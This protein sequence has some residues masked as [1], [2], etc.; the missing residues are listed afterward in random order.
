MGGAVRRAVAT[1]VAPTG[2]RGRPL[3]GARDEAAPFGGTAPPSPAAGGAD[4]GV[5]GGDGGQ[6]DDAAG[7]AIRGQD[8]RGLV[9]AHQ[10]RADRY[11]VG[12]DAEHVVGD[13]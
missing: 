11:A 8:V 12:G 7:G 3:G 4:L 13:V 10:D 5:H 6:V 1:Y 9:E 2:R